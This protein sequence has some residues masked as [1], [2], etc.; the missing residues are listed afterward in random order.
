MCRAGRSPP[1]HTPHSELGLWGEEEGGTGRPGW[2]ASPFL[3]A[4]AGPDGQPGGDGL[5][6]E[7]GQKDVPEGEVGTS[8]SYL[9]GSPEGTCASCP[10]MQSKDHGE[11]G[12]HPFTVRAKLRDSW[13]K[14]PEPGSTGPV[15]NQPQ[16]P[17]AGQLQPRAPGG[18]RSSPRESDAP[19]T[20]PG[21][22]PH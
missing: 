18:R 16:D 5:R 17:R 13:R 21:G 10:W 6:P 8:G 1:P 7:E 14:D 19:H 9:T 20:C 22:S 2:A 11:V 12:Q 3:G 4:S 15:I